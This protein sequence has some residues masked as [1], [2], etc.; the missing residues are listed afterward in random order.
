M[1]IK[2]PEISSRELKNICKQQVRMVTGFPTGHGHLQ[3]HLYTISVSDTS[4]SKKWGE[5]EETSYHLLSERDSIATQR[6][7]V[8]EKPFSDLKNIRDKSINDILKTARQTG[9]F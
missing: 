5:T 6:Q 7:L 4:M 3:K 2:K 1:L 9:F 8:L